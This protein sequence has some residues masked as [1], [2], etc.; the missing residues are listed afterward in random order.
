MQTHALWPQNV[1]FVTAETL[2]CFPCGLSG[3]DQLGPARLR[4]GVEPGNQGSVSAHPWSGDHGASSAVMGE[5]PGPTYRN[6]ACPFSPP[7]SR[8]S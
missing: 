4:C 8:L 1:P 2:G 3:S 5:K 7:V 6:L